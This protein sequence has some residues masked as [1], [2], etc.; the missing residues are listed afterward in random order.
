MKFKNIIAGTVAALLLSITVFA[1]GTIY[2]VKPGD[3]LSKIA[4]RYGIGVSEL[5]KVNPKLKS[6]SAIYPGQSIN[7]PSA[8]STAESYEN[9]VIALVNKE[10]SKRG[11]SML[12]KDAR[13][14]R[15]A[16]LKSQ[17]MVTKNY[18]SHTSPVYGSPFTMMQ[19]FGIRFTA[20]GENIAMGQKTPEAVMSAW[21]NSPG[22]RS[23]ILS[24]AYNRIGIGYARKS[25]GVAYWTQEFIKAA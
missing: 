16:R 5:Q 24:P 11:L 17:E 15:T 23:N 7:I 8:S 18:F 6:A 12:A 22:H 13:L 3:S 21:M 9:K 20:A 1:Q 25:N 2:I 14:A 10:R 19:S 4:N